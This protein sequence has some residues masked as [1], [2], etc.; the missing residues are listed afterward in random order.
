MSFLGDRPIYCAVFILL[1]FAFISADSAP[2]PSATA[3]P[4]PDLVITEMRVMRL[5]GE[6]DLHRFGAVIRNVGNAA[7]P[8]G[9][10]HGVSFWVDGQAVSWSDTWTTSLAPGESTLVTAN[11][12]PLYTLYWNG[13]GA[14]EFEVTGWVNDLAR[15]EEADFEDNRYTR[16]FSYDGVFQLRDIQANYPFEDR[17]SFGITAI[18]EYPHWDFPPEA[19]AIF[20]VNDAVVGTVRFEVPGVAVPFHPARWLQVTLPDAGAAPAGEHRIAMT[21]DGTHFIERWVHFNPRQG[22]PDLVVSKISLDP[23]AD[24]SQIIVP[25]V[26]VTNQG[27]EPTPEGVIHRVDFFV[28]GERRAWSNTWT[29]SIAPGES[30]ELEPD[31]GPVGIAGVYVPLWASVLTVVLDP[32]GLIA[33]SLVDNNQRKAGVITHGRTGY[34]PWDNIVEAVHWSPA[35]PRPG[36]EVTFAA[37]VRLT[38]IQPTTSNDL[39]LAFFVNGEQVS[40]AHPA[41][42]PATNES[43]EMTARQ[44]WTAQPGDFEIYAFVDPQNHFAEENYLNNILGRKLRISARSGFARWQEEHFSPSE[45]ADP[46]ISGPTVEGFDGISNLLRYAL[47]L[48]RNSAATERRPHLVFSSGNPALRYERP[49][50][51]P[52]V[53]YQVQ[54]STDLV[55]W[56]EIETGPKLVA[57]ADGIQ[58]WEARSNSE[59]TALFYRLVVNLKQN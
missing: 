40:M 52:D 34:P 36:D 1:G 53:D 6:P 32:N 54:Q 35:D 39:D 38:G 11:Y 47:G 26:T 27:D 4:L 17:N 46:A 51:R 55:N 56:I 33:E 25:K 59:T 44:T 57:E 15:I 8:E 28:Q 31:G 42:S 16:S 20:E 2:D 45:L 14:T 48:G 21:T 50:D 19:E 7:T 49:M 41:P 43:L 22:K 37:T 23:P 30:I 18:L 13:E 24:F 3:A 29:T 10:V 9:V 12:G 58:T 5:D